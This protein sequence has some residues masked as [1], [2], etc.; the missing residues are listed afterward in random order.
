MLDF[1]KQPEKMITL[2]AK[3]NERVAKETE[4]IYGTK[5]AK[6]LDKEVKAW[7]SS[8]IP[9]ELAL[10]ARNTYI[11]TEAELAIKCGAK[12]CAAPKPEAVAPRLL[13]DDAGTR[14]H[15]LQD[16]TFR[17]PK[18][19]AFFLFRS[20]LL[21]TSPK[22]S[23]T[24]ELFQAIF[25]DVLQDQ[26]YQAALAGL[27]TS[28][29]A[30]Y[31]GLFLTAQGYSARMPELIEYVSGQVRTAELTSLA[32][33]RQREALRQTLSNFDRKQ[34]V[35][36]CSYRRNLALE[37]PRYTIQSSSRPSRRSPSPTSSPSSGRCCPRH[38]WRRSSRV[39]SIRA[40]PRGCWARS[41]R[42]PEPRGARLRADSAP[43]GAH[44]AARAP[45]AAVCGAQPER[46]ELGHGGLPTDRHG[47]GRQLAPPPSG[48]AAHLAALLRR[49]AYQAAA[50]LHRA[51]RGE[52]ELRRARAG[53]S[54]SRACCRR[55]RSRSASTP[56]RPITAL[57]NLP[58]AELAT[59]KESLASQ[60]VDGQRLGAQASRFWGEICSAATTMDGRGATQRACAGSR[61]SRSSTFTTRTSRRPDH[62]RCG[63]SPRSCLRRPHQA[64]SYANACG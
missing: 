2:E 12:S 13:V 6:P 4:P 14:V 26:T 47:H 19:F 45:P 61:S 46:A 39:T 44:P 30:E 56:S 51:V 59:V 23:V 48:L 60:F 34:P 17:R 29:A 28:L 36:L 50:G 25:A 7:A 16:A 31:N 20:D 53:L 5:Y 32:F 41:Q 24:A 3:T 8:P 22:A 63:G 27:G 15:L 54:R 9:P 43:A 18:A 49:A 42:H 21:S 52:R 1:C 35:S 58:D 11:P 40:M 37:R 55:P 57:A 10:P 33:G 62:H 38:T 64:N